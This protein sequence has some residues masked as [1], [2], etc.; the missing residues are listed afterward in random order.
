MDG[1]AN[2]S[3][4]CLFCYTSFGKNGGIHNQSLWLSIN[5]IS[6]GKKCAGKYLESIVKTLQKW[7]TGRLRLGNTTKK[8]VKGLAIN[9]QRDTPRC[10]P[11]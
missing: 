11:L 4:P 1:R 9:L 6:W 5:F 8:N 2:L 10:G 7:R 3:L